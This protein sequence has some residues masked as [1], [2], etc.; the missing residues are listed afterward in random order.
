MSAAKKNAPTGGTVEARQNQRSEGNLKTGQQAVYRKVRSIGSRATLD[1][2]CL[3]GSRTAV[4]ESLRERD[5]LAKVRAPMTYTPPELA[6]R[7]SAL[8]LEECPG[9]DTESQIA[10]ALLILEDGWSVSTLD[11]RTYGDIPHP[12]G[13][14]AELRERGHEIAMTWIRQLTSAGKPHRFGTY[15]LMRREVA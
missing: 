8:T 7:L 1:A 10:R 12:A 4:I 3:K 6:F 9:I 2:A 5:R 14:I 15:K 13:R 11:L